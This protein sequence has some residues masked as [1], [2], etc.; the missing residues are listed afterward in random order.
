[1]FRY[2]LDSNRYSVSN[3]FEVILT[4]KLEVKHHLHALCKNR[5][6]LEGSRLEHEIDR[7]K[8][9]TEKERVYHMGFMFINPGCHLY[10]GENFC[11]TDFL[12]VRD[13]QALKI[14][15]DE[16]KMQVLQPFIRTSLN[17]SGAICREKQV[18][19]GLTQSLKLQV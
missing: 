16:V 1:M 15:P 13:L 17:F 14:L 10:I 11:L 7:Q 4:R 2:G 5:T 8:N 19:R 12:I 9:E 6:Q 3:F 18:S